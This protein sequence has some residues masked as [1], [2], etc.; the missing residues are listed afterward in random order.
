[1]LF[2]SGGFSL[3]D[4]GLTTDPLLDDLFVVTELLGEEFAEEEDV[5]TSVEED[6]FDS[7][8]SSVSLSKRQAL[9]KRAKLN[10]K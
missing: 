7:F 9:N 4:D 10:N 3:E 1:M 8:S 2:R 6:D 5:I